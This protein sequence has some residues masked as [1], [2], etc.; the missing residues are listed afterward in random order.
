MHIPL[1]SDGLNI[2]Q[3]LLCLCTPQCRTQSHRTQHAGDTGT[4]VSHDSHTPAVPLLKT[5]RMVLKVHLTVPGLET[6]HT[7]HYVLSRLSYLTLCNPMD[8][9]LP[10]S[11]VHGILQA[12]ILEWVVMP[13][14]RDLPDPGVEPASFMS[15][16]LA[17]GF[18][19]TRHTLTLWSADHHGKTTLPKDTTYR[20]RRLSEKSILYKVCL[21]NKAPIEKMQRKLLRSEIS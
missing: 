15:P 9:S 3:H 13:F 4:R 5:G 19:A 14:S 8:C 2:W 16:A 1:W 12:R 18:F 7:L 11:P 17:G 6:S 21:G 10:G 20:E